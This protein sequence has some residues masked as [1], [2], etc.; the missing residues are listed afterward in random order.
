MCVCFSLLT[1]VFLL[2]DGLTC[3]LFVS[4]LGSVAGRVAESIRAFIS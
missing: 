4:I 3:V 1:L 2:I